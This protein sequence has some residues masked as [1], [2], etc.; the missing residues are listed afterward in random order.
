MNIQ[1]I[2]THLMATQA[3]VNRTFP[4]QSLQAIKK[5]IKTSELRHRGEIR[6]AVEGGL[7]LELLLK[8][9]SS[10][11]RALDVF[12]QLHVWDTE[13]NNGVLIYLLLADR[14]VEIVADR[15]IH[16]KVNVQDWE[17]ICREMEARFRQGD[18]A[19]GLIQGIESVT[20]MLESHFPAEPGR[21]NELSDAPI[22]L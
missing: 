15:G 11:Q 12:S 10:N 3:H 17:N 6:F 4:A 18:F 16:S 5:A 2:C 22:V 20:I 14:N 9:Q 13:H 19:N 7:D 1:R 21:R 8:D